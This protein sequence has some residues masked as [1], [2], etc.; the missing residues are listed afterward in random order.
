MNKKNKKQNREGGGLEGVQR[1]NK[2]RL[3]KHA[4]IPGSWFVE[5]QFTTPMKSLAIHTI[6]IWSW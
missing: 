3:E 4:V 5:T 6:P 1:A 2:H